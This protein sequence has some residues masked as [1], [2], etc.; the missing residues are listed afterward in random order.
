MMDSGVML[1]VLCKYIQSDNVSDKEAAITTIGNIGSTV[2]GAR[3]LLRGTTEQSDKMMK[4][5]FENMY[6]VQDLHRRSFLQSLAV[7][8]SCADEALVQECWDKAE[9]EVARRGA[10]GGEG[11]L[12]RVLFGNMKSNDEELRFGTM[13][14]VGSVAKKK[15]GIKK[16]FE[17]AGF[18]EYLTDRESEASKIGKEWKYAIISNVVMNHTEEEVS[19]FVGKE[20][21]KELVV[22]LRTG[23]YGIKP[24]STV[25]VIDESI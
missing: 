10:A 12:M 24:K 1:E 8:W 4:S 25:D 22:Y 9:E 19:K 15:F 14:V 7:F 16:M 6:A 5:Y 17:E 13:S 18:Y 2:T 20:N 23:V 3:V 11:R 21:Y